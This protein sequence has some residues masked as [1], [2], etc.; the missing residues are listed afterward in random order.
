MERE[1]LSARAEL[2]ALEREAADAAP[3]ANSRS[4]D[5]G[6]VSL[7]GGVNSAS[8]PEEKLAEFAQRFVGREDAYA[9]RWVS[10]KTGKAGWSPAVKGGFYTDSKSNADLLPLNY[11][12]LERH[13]RG[14]GEGEREFHA[15]L[16]PMTVDDQC[17]L[18]VCDFDGDTWRDDA[19]A[20]SDACTDFGIGRLAE[21]SRS[22]DGAHVWIFFDTWLPAAVARRAGMAILRAAMH[23][24]GTLPLGSYDRLFPS[25]DILPSQ[26]PGRMRLGNLI[27]LPLQ[28]NC[29]RR[30]TTVFADP[31]TWE[32][33]GDQ[34]SVLSSTVR[35][36][37]EKVDEVAAQ[38]VVEIGPAQ[39]AWVPKRPLAKE[40]RS[41]LEGQVLE[42]TRDSVL[43]IPTESM[44][45]TFISEFKHRASISNPEFYRRQAQ[46]FS[47]FGVPR[48]VTC[49]EHD[50]HELRLPRGLADET[51]QLLK[52]GGAKV[53]IRNKVRRPR[54]LD[55]QFTGRLRPDQHRAV[56]AILK[57]QD[58]VLVAPPGTG[59]TVIACALIAER[60][61]ATAILVNR[62]EL[63]HQ[64]RDRL[65][66][67]LD[68]EDQRIGQLGSGRKKR[69]GVIDLIMMQSISRK[70]SDPSILEEYGQVI[71]DECHAIAAPSTEAAI[72][73]VNVKHWVGL[74]ATPFRSDQMD[75]LITMQ[76]G[77]IRHQ[78]EAER[79]EDRRLVIHRTS[80]TTEEPGSDGPSIQAIY[81]ELSHDASRNA[82]IVD[83]IVRAAEDRRTCMV[84]TNRVDHLKSLDARVSL[85]VPGKVF[86]L[87]GQLTAQERRA[88]RQEIAETDRNGD[89][90]VLIA[91]DKIAG[92]GLD[93]PTMDTLFLAMPV[94]FK[95]RIIQQAGRVTRG[96]H[97]GSAVVHDFRDAEV[98]LLERMHRRRRRTL[99]GEG[100]KLEQPAM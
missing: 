41:G 49:F 21:I 73:T 8:S 36:S 39:T 62:A 96:G 24:R 85:K 68:I 38:A 92:E 15:G 29:R 18:L 63:L 98:P 78:I 13:L 55:L 27:A 2:L 87:H 82:L 69:T 37:R 53:T 86:T 22:G 44:P 52:S 79:D 35:A 72:R 3:P 75:G 30:G 45:S 64:W 94:S 9:T 100:F 61:V 93:I 57:H 89:P 31:H 4:A 80:F 28:G 58:G 56:R 66:T 17:K 10:K 34:F 95:G 97:Q 76:C 23:K 99:E 88:V 71:V 84:L 11:T 43:R 60:S 54:K 47:T 67:F 40:L 74:T 90:F 65:T 51:R 26:S 70:G 32:P 14:A 6:S 42:I 16:Y 20:Y 50:Q 12:V 25:Q 19:A 77:P 83:E 91:I 7:A 1:L 5:T 48:I 81:S 59:K 33:Y 46:R